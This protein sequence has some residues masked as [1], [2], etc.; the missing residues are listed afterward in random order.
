MTMTR[1]AALD[2]LPETGGK[3]FQIEGHDILLCRSRAGTFAVRNLC[4]HQ[5]AKLEGGKVKGPH[6]FCPLHG[7]RFD[8]R[9]GTPN[10][11]LTSKPIEIYTTDVIDGVVYAKLPER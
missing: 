6:I 7:V 11:T 5:H 1:I 3:A 4:S 8:L 10:G 9:D 2:D